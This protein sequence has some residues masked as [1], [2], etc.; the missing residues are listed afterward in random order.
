MRDRPVAPPSPTVPRLQRKCAACEKEEQK[1]G[2]ASKVI[3]RRK[4][5]HCQQEEEQLASTSAQSSASAPNVMEDQALHRKPASARPVTEAPPLV[6][7]VLRS[8]GQSLSS[9]DLASSSPALASTLAAFASMRTPLPP[10][11]PN[12]SPR[13]PIPSVLTSPLPQA[14]TSPAPNRTPLARP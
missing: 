4:C 5:A 3:L 14:S 2:S 6:H 8:P 7:R 13:W 9:D 11:P 10:N 12:P 1:N